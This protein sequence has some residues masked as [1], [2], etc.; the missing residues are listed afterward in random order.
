MEAG[1]FG[2]PVIFPFELKFNPSGKPG[3]P[4]AN[5]QMYGAWPPI[6]ASCAV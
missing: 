2:V 6:A 4:G 3:D 5:D 1:P